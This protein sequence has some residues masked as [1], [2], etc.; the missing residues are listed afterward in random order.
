MSERR[1]SGLTYLVVWVAL[2]LLTTL[3]FAL[4]Y[5]HLGAWAPAIAIAIAAT[6]GTLIALYFMHLVEQRASSWLTL[7]IAVILIALLIVLAATDVLTR[8]PL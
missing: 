7:L 1:V 5:A 6:K 4:S 3:T 2:L 8:A